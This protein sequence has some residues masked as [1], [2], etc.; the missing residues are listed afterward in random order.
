MASDSRPKLG[1]ILTRLRL[2]TDA[3]V[4]AALA[5]QAQ[6]GGLFGESLL[7]LG[8]ISE[9]NLSWALSSQLDYPFVAVTAEMAD[10]ELLALFPEDF[11]RRNLVL[12]LVASESSLSVV[13]A[14]PTDEA[15]VKR[16]RFISRMDLEIAVGTPSAIREVLNALLA[17]SEES[18]RLPRIDAGRTRAP[19]SLSSPDLAQLLDRAFSAG[20]VTVHL[21]PE[22][23]HLRVRFRDGAG[24]LTEGGNYEKRSRDR[25]L[26]GL[27]NWLGKGEEPAPG[28][29]I[30]DAAASPDTDLPF[31]AV[32]V[33]GEAGTSL[34]LILRDAWAGHRKLAASFEPEWTRLDRLLHERSGLV[35]A[36]APSVSGREQLL[37][38]FL[39]QLD[40][41]TRRSW[42]VG[43]GNMPRPAGMLVLS[44]PPEAETFLGLAEGDGVD[45][46]AVGLSSHTALPP[47]IEIAG[48]STLVAATVPGNSALGL[49]ARVLESGVSPTLLSQCLLAVTAQRILLP[50][51]PTTSPRAVT[52][53]LFVDAAVR[54]ALQNGGSIPELVRAATLQ[55]FV[56]IAARVGEE[57]GF[58]PHQVAALLR[59]RYLEE[60]A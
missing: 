51:D 41:I 28:V 17:G 60:A 59:Y 14:D 31:R 19:K 43:T 32:T 58:D 44:A 29:R 21:D 27:R 46:L 57:Q 30:W 18:G 36:T 48:H 8:H 7:A 20:A 6:A 42:A 9:D 12:P 49:L 26:E 52:E 2:V 11:L 53:T 33:E 5:H 25:L 13:L 54:R 4:K 50:M 22:Q 16:L 37:G 45:V 38:R 40:A 39:G 3:Q 56:E 35:L 15:T 10:P 1:D 34:T 55:G 23:D 47:L 24:K